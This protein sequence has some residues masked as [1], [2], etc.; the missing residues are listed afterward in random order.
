MNNHATR[1][2]LVFPSSMGASLAHA[3]RLLARGERV[4]AASSV[5]ADETAAH[6]PHWQPLPSIYDAGFAEAL[7]ALIH[8]QNI[9]DIYTPHAVVHTV[10]ARVLAERGLPVQLPEQ[11]P[12]A[13]L[14][15][16]YRT[17]LAEAEDAL[18]FA[19]AIAPNLTQDVVAMASLLQQA[20][21]IY[22]QTSESKLAA[23]AACFATAPHGDVVEIGTAW[24][25]SAFALCMLAQHYGTGAVLAIDP[26]NEGV[27]SQKDSPDALE[28]VNQQID[29]EMMHRIFLIHLL[30]MRERFNYRRMLSV[31]ASED[32]APG[33][34]VETPHFGRTAYAGRVALIHIDGNHDYASVAADVAAWLPKLLPGGWLVL[35]DYVW[36]H[37][38]GPRRVG[39]ALLAEHAGRVAHSFTCGKALFVQFAR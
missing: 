28:Q 8:D 7:Q 18:A 17:L 14:D 34:A 6:Y 33:L 36:E 38:D 21:A 32:H 39:D 30:P 20:N 35:D 12:L 11:S 10:I 25:R 13:A 19:R 22:G 16:T 4:V 23:M 37:G 15:A 9:T 3:R 24:G 26:W 1:T 27:A 31:P 2:T 29:W 5:A